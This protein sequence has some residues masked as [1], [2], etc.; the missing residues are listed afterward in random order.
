MNQCVDSTQYR[1][2]NG[3][4]IERQ[5]AFDDIYDCLDG[6]DEIDDEKRKIRCQQY[7]FG[8]CEEFNCG[9]MTYPIDDNSDC[10]MNSHAR[11]IP[12]DR[13][14]C[15][16]RNGDE[17]SV[18]RQLVQHNRC[19]PQITCT[20]SNDI[21]C[22]LL[23]NGSSTPLAYYL[24][25][26]FCN[27]VVN[28]KLVTDEADCQEFSLSCSS[29]SR[30][31]TGI[32]DCNNGYD[33]INCGSQTYYLNQH[34]GEEEH[35]CFQF[36]TYELGCLHV[37]RAND[38]QIDC[39]GASD[40]RFVYCP[41]KHPD[42]ITRR[43]RCLSEPLCIRVEQVCDGNQDCPLNDDELMCP[44]RMKSECQNG[45]FACKN[46]TCLSESERCN[47]QNECRNG[48]DEWFCDMI[49]YRHFKPQFRLSTDFTQYPI[50]DE[51]S[52][53]M[54][55][56]NWSKLKQRRSVKRADLKQDE[57]F[58]YYI[59][60]YCNH[61][62]LVSSWDTKGLECFCSPAYFG[63]R[64]QFQSH[65]L[66]VY[67]QV[68]IDKRLR[69]SVFKLSVCLISTDDEE[70]TIMCDYVT[71]F[72]SNE[73]IFKHI[74]YLV[75]P[76]SHITSNYSVRITAYAT[77]LST[78]MLH[79]AWYYKIAF[80]FLPVNR[81]TAVIRIENTTEQYKNN[82][83]LYRNDNTRHYC[84]HAP[85]SPLLCA[86][87]SLFVDGYCV[88]PLNKWGTGCYI[89]SNICEKMNDS[90][91][92]GGICYPLVERLSYFCICD[93]QHFG[94]FCQYNRSKVAISLMN[95]HYSI[96]IMPFVIVHFLEIDEALGALIIKDRLLFHR[97]PLS[98]ILISL[99][100]Q[101]RL[102]TF[103]YT[104]IYF[105]TRTVY[106]EYHLVSLLRRVR[107]LQT[108]VLPSNRCPHIRELLNHTVNNF[109][110]FK[111]VKFYQ[112][113]CYVWG[114]KCFYDEQYMCL[115]DNFARYDCFRFDHDASDCSSLDYCLNE[116][117]C[118]QPLQT[119][120]TFDFGC[121]C[122]ACYYGE[123]CQFTTA[124]YSLSLDAL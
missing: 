33:E 89:R 40:E 114:I 26:D 106:G 37:D 65:R 41:N 86:N 107:S 10:F 73:R 79:S 120:L 66:T 15:T 36:D 80:S 108:S 7:P 1:C 24:F 52:N 75:Y 50:R 105:D 21:G 71:H 63:H 90:C 12:V 3:M 72:E 9:W 49:R 117:R 103:I 95:N 58:D 19:I 25:Q 20:S 100:K 5:F 53:E 29:R 48:E 57:L 13:Y 56:K 6:S 123:L 92:N 98:S 77:T 112:K 4:C 104:Q 51:M 91:K 62:V 69:Q 14:N 35:Y 101:E 84:F 45:T 67:L 97:V 88:C 34:C 38:G 102:S 28:R 85:L 8:E 42:E 116:G 83:I 16:N 55:I 118:I 68:E 119:D 70:R 2:R 27:G 81:L 64:C 109:P 76:R 11:T 74:I 99:F 22:Y 32:W 93:D 113:A 30:A 121:V 111:R 87:D 47:N 110:Y 59:A 17:I 43:F 61:G 124:Q 44:W 18:P 96:S 115:C 60:Y 78:V 94:Q 23:R 46:R 31:C 122:P 54:T 39:I 82:C